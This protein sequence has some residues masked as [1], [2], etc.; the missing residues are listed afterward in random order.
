VERIGQGTLYRVSLDR[1][2]VGN[3]IFRLNF[4]I[5]DNDDGYRKQF[6]EW[7]HGLGES[8]DP[9]LWQQFILPAAKMDA[10]NAN[11]SLSK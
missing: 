3:G 5:N 6:M 2:M 10:G 1:A 7:T 11:A 9:T 8:Q 4:L